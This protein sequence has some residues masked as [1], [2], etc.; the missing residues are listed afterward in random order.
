MTASLVD[1]K[2]DWAKTFKRLFVLADDSVN[3]TSLPLVEMSIRRNW[4]R[5]GD[6]TSLILVNNTSGDIDLT[7]HTI[8]VTIGAALLK[9][10]DPTRRYVYT[11]KCTT[12]E[13]EKYDHAKGY[14]FHV[15]SA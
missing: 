8:E 15:P 14:F 10:L 12:S 2:H 7:E 13:G 4:A 11:L 1:L 6:E 5:P 3:A 9:V